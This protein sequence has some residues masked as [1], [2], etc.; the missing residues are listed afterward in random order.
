MNYILQFVLRVLPFKL[1]FIKRYVDDILLCLPA[2]ELDNLL[3]YFNSFNH[4]IQFTLEKEDTLCSVP[5]LDTRV[6]RKNNILLVDWY[7]KPLS[8]GRYLNYSSYH[9]HAMKI[10][11][12]KAMKNRVLKISDVSFH[13][14]NLKILLHL[15]LENGYPETLLRKLLFNTSNIQPTIVNNNVDA[16]NSQTIDIPNTNVA[17]MTLPYTSEIAPKLTRLFKPFENIKLAFRTAL[18][19]NRVFSKV[20]EK[21]PV[22]SKTDTVYSLPCLNCNQIYIGQTSRRLKDRITS[23][24]SDCRLYPDR[25]ALGE[26]SFNNDHRIDYN[27]VR[28]LDRESHA[29]KRLFLEMVHI[30]KNPNSMNH[31]TDIGHLNEMFSYLLYLDNRESSHNSHSRD[32]EL[33]STL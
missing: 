8:S 23:H 18:T 27:N 31:R 15:F 13:S 6:I 2:N 16:D 32:S 22:L 11:L 21:T 3:L 1:F 20:K 30:N 12:I 9:K 28:V 19:V 33:S 25:S 17:Y 7:R 14:K 5:F 26:H 10:N 29:A 24:R 4:H